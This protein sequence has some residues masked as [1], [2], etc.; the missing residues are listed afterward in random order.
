MIT[1]QTITDS[2]ELL[3]E[4]ENVRSKGFAINDGEA[5]ESIRSAAA[6]IILDDCVIG[7]IGIG[8]HRHRITKERLHETLSEMALGISNEIELLMTDHDRRDL[9]N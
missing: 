4:L 7:A 2:E 1:E 5:I 6:P 3:S 8:G 9:F